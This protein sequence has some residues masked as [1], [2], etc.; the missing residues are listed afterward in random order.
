MNGS[1]DNS[2][3]IIKSTSARIVNVLDKGYGSAL[4]NGIKEAKGKYV[5]MCDS[6]DSYDLD[7]LMIFLEKL[8]KNYDLVMGNRYKG[9]FEKGS[10]SFSHYY[11]VKF[12]TFLGNFLYHTKL[13]DYHCGLRGFNRNKINDNTCFYVSKFDINLAKNAAK[14]FIGV[15][16][17]QNFVSGTRDNYDCIIYK[18]KFKRKKDGIL[19]KFYGKSFYRYMV[20]NLVG[21]IIDVAKKKKDISYIDYLLNSNKTDKMLS[22]APA[23]GLTLEKI[24]Y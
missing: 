4:I 6:D 5:I 1:T 13:G 23:K 17:F 22:T 18:I 20:R 11:G 21:A 12:L 3:D 8:R 9:G 24:Y 14:K 10:I 19:I 7:N 2:I 16:N 15:H